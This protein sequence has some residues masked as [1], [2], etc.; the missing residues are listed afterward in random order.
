MEDKYVRGSRGMMIEE[1]IVMLCYP[2]FFINSFYKYFPFMHNVCLFIPLSIYYVCMVNTFYF[3]LL[4]FKYF[5]L[6]FGPRGWNHGEG[7][8]IMRGKGVGVIFHP[9]CLV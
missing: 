7:V 9:F 8:F 6:C 2:H 3:P 5:T 1:S 4:Y